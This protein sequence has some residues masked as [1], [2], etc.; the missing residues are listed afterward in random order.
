[1]TWF[2][3]RALEI[4]KAGINF[5]VL[6]SEFA[7][8]YDKGWGIVTSDRAY[9]ILGGDYGIRGQPASPYSWHQ[10][11]RAYTTTGFVGRGSGDLDKAFMNL[12]GTDQVNLSHR[13]AKFQMEKYLFQMK[14]GMGKRFRNVYGNAITNLE[15]FEMGCLYYDNIIANTEAWKEHIRKT[16]EYV[17]A[18]AGG[19]V[20]DRIKSRYFS[21]G[22]RDW[23]P[24]T[25]GTQVRK[26]EQQDSYNRTYEDV[27]MPYAMVPMWGITG[28]NT[29][30]PDNWHNYTYKH[31][32]WPRDASLIKTVGFGAGGK[33]DRNVA[34]RAG[35]QRTAPFLVKRGRRGTSTMRGGGFAETNIPYSQKYGRFGRIFTP[36]KRSQL[37]DVVAYLAPTSGY[38]NSPRNGGRGTVWVGDIIEPFHMTPW[39]FNHETGFTTNK[40]AKVPA[41]PF[42]TPGIK[43]GANDAAR[44]MAEYMKDG[45]TNRR[46]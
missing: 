38:V 20:G 35:L 26:L 12:M 9:T 7:R 25:M 4:E 10:Q 29:G 13:E 14:G 5:N 31:A 18:H 32:A 30:L 19:I 21:A 41:R 27:H 37:M 24:N 42:I 6:G 34:G 44:L 8:D 11:M 23:A 33:P 15:N 1:M 16:A 40:G 36:R 17:S 39:V 22:K 46:Y 45:T 3:E 2:D 28:R 43:D